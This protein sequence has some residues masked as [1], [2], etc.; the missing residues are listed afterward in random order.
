M[1]NF[2]SDD[3]YPTYTNAFFLCPQR[4]ILRK[5]TKV[6]KIDPSSSFAKQLQ[7][8]RLL[9]EKKEFQEEI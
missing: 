9:S 1:M 7:H 6:C 5:E 2:Y 3:P 4:L 8:R